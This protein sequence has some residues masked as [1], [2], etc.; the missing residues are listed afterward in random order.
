[1]QDIFAYIDQHLNDYVDQLVRLCRQPS[2]SAQGQGVVEAAHLLHDMMSAAEIRTR[3]VP[4]PRCDFPV[5]YGEMAGESPYTIL[6]YNHYD[7]Q[8][9]EP[10]DL[11][12][13][14]PFQPSIRDGRVYARGVS[15]NKG[16]IVARLAAIDAYRAVRGSLPASV[17]LC[18]E[19]EEETGSAH[20]LEFV[21]Q[22]R[23]L[24]RA[25][26]CIW[27]GGGQTWGG[28]PQVILGLK[29]IL[30][31]ELEARGATRDIHS[32]WATVV[33]NPAWRLTWALRSLKGPDE[34][35]LVPGFYAPAPPPPP[36]ELDA[37]RAMPS[38]DAELANSLGLPSFIQGLSGFEFRR[39]HLLEPTCTICGLASGYGGPGSKTVLPSVA[40]AKLDFRLVPD[41]RSEDIL[42][43]LKA[44]LA[45]SGF[46][47]V[48][49]TELGGEEPARTP[50][51]APFVR[52][53]S[54]TAREVYG[55]EPVLVPTM[56][57]SGPMY[58]F[59]DI[60]G[61]PTVGCGIEYPDARPHAPDENL[62]IE[63]FRLGIKHI[64]SILG[65][66]A[67]NQ[68]TRPAKKR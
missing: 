31:V 3:V 37:V 55:K 50:L 36:A 39:R 58:A 65:R 40:R 17:K 45:N 19:G 9:V 61:L 53:A 1:M 16:N 22:H 35:I 52:V 68:G 25:D 56:A 21:R 11:W 33:P 7:V 43:K 4:V 5:V 57:G 32:S 20:L 51:D 27:E 54:G 38:E 34:R 18:A 2:V 26:A 44:H 48:S 62:R 23:D 59:T 67:D 28:Q 6:F 46:D 10:L 24:L 8:P 42:A 12:T 60:L 14:P 47:D 13:S 15:D 30:Y 49:V 41:Q 66:F 64:V 29:G 63:D